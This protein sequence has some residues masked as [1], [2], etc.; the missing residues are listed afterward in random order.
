M[1]N[2]L[3]PEENLQK[4]ES[5]FF[6]LHKVR[7]MR[8]HS[9]LG[10]KCSVV[11][12]CLEEKYKA[13]MLNCSITNQHGETFHSEDFLNGPIQ[14]KIEIF[15]TFE[16]NTISSGIQIKLSAH[17]VLKNNLHFLFICKSCFREGVICHW[18]I[19]VF[20]PLSLFTSVLFVLLVFES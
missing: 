2:Y 13:H 19:F 8:V 9:A 20:N 16:R 3:L 11:W 17:F 6:L 1:A 5:Y 15:K 10:I 18:Q 4:N 14:I 7:W 12:G